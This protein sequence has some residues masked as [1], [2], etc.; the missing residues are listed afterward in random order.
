[1]T[2]GALLCATIIG[3]LDRISHRGILYYAFMALPGVCVLLLSLRSTFL[4]SLFLLVAIGFS[5]TAF[6]ITWDSAV[7]EL[8]DEQVL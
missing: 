1:M 8:V 7:Q 2:I 4:L 6:I 3:R 5:L